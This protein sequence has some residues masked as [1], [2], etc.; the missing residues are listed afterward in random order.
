M[1]LFQ[2]QP[3]PIFTTETVKIIDRTFQQPPA[4]VP[5]TAAPPQ[6]Q[7]V[8]PTQNNNIVPI[9]AIVSLLGFFGLLAFMA[10]CKR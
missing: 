8:N 1:A 2:P 3:T 4:F 10:F 7:Y 6:F 5:L 9:V